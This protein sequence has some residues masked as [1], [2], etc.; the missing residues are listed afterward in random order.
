MRIISW[1][2]QGILVT[3]TVLLLL[4]IQRRHKPDVFFLFETH[5]DDEKAEAL[6]RRLGMD[7][8]IVVPSPDGRRGGLLMVW[9]KEVRIY[10][11]TTTLTGIDV[12]IHETNGNIWRLTGIYGEPSWEHKDRTYRYIRDLHT[13]SRLPWV[14]IG[15]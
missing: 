3:P 7:E 13:H 10:S 15:D 2:C 5:L 9:K 6:R 11:Q 12:N 8:K 1:N 4:D 14:T